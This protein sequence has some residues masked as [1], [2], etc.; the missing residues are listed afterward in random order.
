MVY[1]RA[2]NLGIGDRRCAIHGKWQPIHA[3][4]IYSVTMYDQGKRIAH[5]HARHIASGIRSCPT[6]RQ[7]VQQMVAVPRSNVW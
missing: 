3:P 7:I 4:R 5:L 6:H 2:R 1:I